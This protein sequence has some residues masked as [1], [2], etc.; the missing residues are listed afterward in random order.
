MPD[1]FYMTT[2]IYYVNDLPHLGTAYSTIIA[3]IFTR[4]HRFFGS[5]SFLLTGI[6]EHGQKCEQAAQSQKKET[7]LYCDQMSAQFEKTW[8]ALDIHYNSFLRTSSDRHKKVVQEALK[9]LQEK[10]DIYSDVYKGWYCV[11]EET[12]YT[13]KD[14]VD[15][16]SPTGK[17]VVYI[18]EK[19]YFFKMSKYQK[20]LQKHLEDHPDFIQPSYRQNEIKG[21][22]KQDLQDL[23]ISR[24]KSRVSWGVELPFDQD[25][26]AYVWVD[27]LLNYLTGVF[28]LEDS[29]KFDKW[30][31][32]AGTV[33]LIGKDILMTHGVYWPCLLMALDLP[34][35]KTLFAHGWLLN[36]EQ[37][38]MSKSKGDKLD[39][40]ELAGLF[41]VSE[42]RYF[43]AREIILGN[44]APVS[45]S[46][47]AQKINS[48]LSDQLGNIL[49][50]LCRLV[51]KNY[52]GKINKPEGG[53]GEVFKQKTEQL[54]LE[55]EKDI[56]AFKLSQALDKIS[57]RLSEVNRYLED[58]APWTMVKTDKE[59][60]ACVL[61]NSLEVL[62]ICSL[63]LYPVMPQKINQLL[64]HLGEEVS[65]KSLK[66]GRLPLGKDI[67][68]CQ[69]LFPKIVLS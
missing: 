7:Q 30:W 9:K 5:E 51:D 56:K 2:P 16:K 31:K 29:K 20:A 11:S 52:E 53:R 45:K 33:H 28:Y 6:D 1:L 25:Y 54:L 34:L 66:W 4:Y 63:L 44:D 59:G 19:N 18:E 8:K 24:P 64:Q 57:Q 15:Q 60:A 37:S 61:Y 42:L 12:F 10:G 27:A 49:S 47:M 46:L 48:D 41:G 69:P 39:P 68:H 67:K 21:F 65:L 35:P 43:L 14:L 36:E 32:Q 40:L 13:E 23:C 55:V 58:Q 26:V 50:R 22:L 38:K 17:E 3:D 62:R